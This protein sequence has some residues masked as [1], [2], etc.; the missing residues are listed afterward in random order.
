MAV[1]QIGMPGVRH[2]SGFTNQHRQRRLQAVREIPGLRL[3]ASHGAF[4]VLEQGVETVDD[5]LHFDRIAAVNTPGFTGA[6]R[7]ELV[8]EPAERRNRTTKLPQAGEHADDGDSRRQR[9]VLEHAVQQARCRWISEHE[10]RRH[11]ARDHEE[12]QRPEGGAEQ[13]AR[14]ER[15][16][17]SHRSPSTMR[18]PRPRTVSMTVAPS[19]RRSLAMKTSTVFES[20]SLSSG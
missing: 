11:G 14:A 16:L 17:R 2:T 19:F 8:A 7:A 9:G 4:L 1:A 20:R 18:Y 15:E 13:Q 5:G 10:H 6:H 3:S 12:P